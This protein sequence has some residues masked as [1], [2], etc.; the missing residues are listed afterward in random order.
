MSD[1]PNANRDVVLFG[2]GDVSQVISVYVERYSDLNIV[3]YTVDAEFMPESGTF[4]GKPCVPWEEIETHHPPGSVKLLGPLTYKRLNQVRRERY[5]EGKAKGY[6]FASFIHPACH[7]NT[8]AI[9]DHA[10][11]LEANIIQPFATIGDNVIIWSGNHIGHH[12]TIGSHCFI[13]SQVGIAGSSKIGEACYLAGQV[14]IIHGLTVGDRCAIL[15][16]AFVKSD[17]P[18]DSVV[19]GEGDPIKPYPSRRIAHLL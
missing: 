18:D 12:V 2:T 6:E 17:V 11:I 1:S 13:A 19:T 5:L 7:I 9:G 10:I 3:G 14:G 16:G 8:E 4:N 15:N